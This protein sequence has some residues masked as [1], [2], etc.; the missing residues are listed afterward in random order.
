MDKQ[1]LSP[2]GTVKAMIEGLVERGEQVLA[3]HPGMDHLRRL[4]PSVRSA[5]PDFRAE[6]SNRSSTATGLPVSGPSVAHTKVRYSAC[7]Q[8]GNRFTSKT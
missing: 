2:A 6:L 1:V 4:W 8:V 7:L 3:P 5:I